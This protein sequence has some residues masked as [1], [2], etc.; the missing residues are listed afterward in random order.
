VRRRT[1]YIAFSTCVA[2]SIAS[3]AG[4]VWPERSVGDLSIFVTLQRFRMYADHCSAMVPQLKPKFEG[5]MDGL[6]NRIEEV[7]K[8]L[9]SSDAFRVMKDKPVPAEIG[10]AFQDSL[11]D[12][13]HNLERQDAASVCQKAL[14]NLGDTN[15]E[16][17]KVALEQ[18]LLAVQNMT[19]NLEKQS[20]RQTSPDNRMQRSRSP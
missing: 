18:S 9:L 16:T 8:G 19:R 1:I 12:A 15:D 7:S 3:G 20:A 2:G 14:R 10:F 4:A 13:R 17:L 11:E 5:L 6:N